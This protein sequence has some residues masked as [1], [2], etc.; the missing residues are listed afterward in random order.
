VFPNLKL[1]QKLFAPGTPFLGFFP[2]DCTA[3]WGGRAC[4]KSQSPA[5]WEL[6]LLKR[7]ARSV[8]SSLFRIKRKT[9]GLKMPFL[10]FETGLQVEILFWL[11]SS[12]RFCVVQV[13]IVALPSNI[14]LA[15]T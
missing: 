13:W 11:F 15:E 2:F 9:A 4:S 1:V 6:M 7:E 14:L 12:L 8:Q 5:V 3:K 10:Y